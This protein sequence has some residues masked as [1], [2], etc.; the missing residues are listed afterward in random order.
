MNGKVFKSYELC[1]F[2][3]KCMDSEQYPQKFLIQ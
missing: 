1:H 3:T 2:V